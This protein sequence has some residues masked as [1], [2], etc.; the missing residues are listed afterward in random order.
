MRESDVEKYLV[1]RV[2]DCGA[3]AEKFTSP[4]RKFVPDRIILLGGSEVCF[5]ECKAT[6]EKPNVGQL[7][8][9][10]RRR[11]LGYRVYVV[12]SRQS[13]NDFLKREGFF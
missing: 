8:D 5:V 4:N 13:I 1:V 11:A 12:D 6:G 9:H 2:A 7:R 10:E 3:V